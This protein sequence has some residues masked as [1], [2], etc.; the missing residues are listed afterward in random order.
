MLWYSR[1]ALLPVFEEGLFS[2]TSHP[3]HQHVCGV[4][5]RGCGTA[6]YSGLCHAT[7][8]RGLARGHP[9]PRQ[10]P[11]VAAALFRAASDPGTFLRLQL[12]A[13]QL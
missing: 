2:H 7:Y 1:E 8:Q 13:H 11:S 5:W 4:W 10:H 6:Q 3:E 12:Q 9:F